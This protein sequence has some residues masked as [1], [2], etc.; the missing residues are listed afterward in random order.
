MALRI[1]IFFLICLL[2]FTFQISQR[3]AHA[4]CLCFIA[5]FSGKM[6]LFNFTRPKN[7]N[8]LF[9]YHI[10]VLICPRKIFKA[11][12]SKMCQLDIATEFTLV[13]SIFICDLHLSLLISL[14][15]LQSSVLPLPKSAF[16]LNFSW[17]T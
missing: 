13:T 12:I 7:P 16:S 3:A 15:W 9:C 4:F 2:L 1:L 14:Y 10:R 17:D 6:C 11:G 5:A 8:E